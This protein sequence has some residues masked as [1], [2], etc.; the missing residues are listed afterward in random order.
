MNNGRG[1]RLPTFKGDFMNER[2]YDI[3]TTELYMSQIER[4][5]NLIDSVLD[6]TKVIPEGNI[7]ELS[8]NVA[9][10]SGK[11]E[12][13]YMMELIDKDVYDQQVIRLRESLEEVRSNAFSRRNI[14]KIF[15]RKK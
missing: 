10:M 1:L 14:S 9:F 7:F 4:L 15:G 8:T 6:T 2:L 5:D 11:L 13:L 12:A 3:L